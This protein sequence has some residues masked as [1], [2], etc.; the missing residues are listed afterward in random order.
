MANHGAAT[1]L[2]I[3][4]LLVTVALS[5]A[6]ARL[7]AV[8]HNMAALSGAKDNAM[9]TVRRDTHGGMQLHTPTRRPSNHLA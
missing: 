5:G 1:L 4:S 2:L 8:R 3:A 6:D 9:F 7:T